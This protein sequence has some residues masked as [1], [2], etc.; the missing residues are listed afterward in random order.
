MMGTVW[1]PTYLLIYHTRDLTPNQG[2][3]SNGHSMPKSASTATNKNRGGQEILTA[4]V[5][6][7]TPNA[8][9]RN[10]ALDEDRPILQVADHLLT[11][12]NRDIVLLVVRLA[13]PQVVGADLDKEA[14]WTLA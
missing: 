7:Q 14:A 12:L 2:A 1:D 5:T 13:F 3:L 11:L 4:S 8:G 10:S 6:R 9:S